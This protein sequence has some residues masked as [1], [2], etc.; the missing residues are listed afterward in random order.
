MTLD[1][2]I[3]EP[4][5]VV[6][7]GGSGRPLS[8]FHEK[9]LP[10]RGGLAFWL[11]SDNQQAVAMLNFLRLC[12]IGYSLKPKR[13]VVITDRQLAERRLASISHAELRSI[14]LWILEHENGME[15]S[16][17]E[18]HSIASPILWSQSILR[19]HV[20]TCRTGSD[21]KVSSSKKNRK[22]ITAS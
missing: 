20:F 12:D 14:L 19:R 2:I 15:C 8:A 13:K 17:P 9:Q 4:W 22:E 6:W 10:S 11:P 5:H 18:C 16:H 7:L 21:R 3:A 1:A